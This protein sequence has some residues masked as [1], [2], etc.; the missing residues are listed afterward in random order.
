M[1]SSI[2]YPSLTSELDPILRVLETRQEPTLAYDPTGIKR[3]L[4]LVLSHLR[5]GVRD[6]LQV[7]VLFSVK[8]NPNVE[9]LRWLAAEGVG[10][11]ISS[12]H[13]FEV[14]KRAGMQLISATAPGLSAANV[15]TLCEHGVRVNIDNP[16]Q[17]NGVSPGSKIGLRLCLPLDLLPDSQ[18]TG[19]SR[20]G[21]TLDSP[22]LRETLKLRK[23]SVVRIQAHFRD[24]AN[25]AQLQALA[26]RVVAAAKA[27]PGV[28][29]INLGGGMTRL[30][31]DPV[32]AGQ[33]WD[34]CAEIFD[35]LDPAT[36]LYVEP[37]AQLL[38]RHGYLSTRV[39]SATERPDGRIL[40]VVDSSKW[41]LVCWSELQLVH[42][43]Q[44][45]RG[46]WADVVGPTCYE[47]DIWVNG[48]C[49]P[50]V[51]PGQQL[52]FRGLGAYVTSMARKMHGLPLPEEVLLPLLVPAPVDCAGSQPE[53]GEAKDDQDGEIGAIGSQ[54]AQ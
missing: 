45:E 3:E 10:A 20:F 17:L 41:N 48:V 32:A 27:F 15:T 43:E 52:I 53:S 36:T 34:Q 51:R 23:C 25:A 8:A 1:A 26:S 14:A 30:Y 54:S 49:L 7:K 12:M 29:E 22:L 19:Y 2:T 5:R 28:L 18:N 44:T 21:V 47:K 6:R 40:I 11:E 31:K 50:E 13:E 16:A 4:E 42:P 46:M 39:V 33:A 24:I 9:L 38:T 35:E 37:G